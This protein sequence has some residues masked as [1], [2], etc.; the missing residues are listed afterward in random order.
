MISLQPGT[1]KTNQC[2]G[3]QRRRWGL[4]EEAT[5]ESRT[6]WRKEGGHR[7][8]WRKAALGSQW[9]VQRSRGRAELAKF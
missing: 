6:E 2:V 7:K 4:S 5:S 3:R 8:G 1:G 9:Q